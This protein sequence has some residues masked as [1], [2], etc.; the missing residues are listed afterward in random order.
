[1]HDLA[2]HHSF[3]RDGT[4][5][6]EGVR[7]SPLQ[8]ASN[9]VAAGKEES[10]AAIQWIARYVCKLTTGAEKRPGPATAKCS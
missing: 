1:M 7:F 4:R 9:L 3:L 2:E 8:D 6:F 10:G 5:C